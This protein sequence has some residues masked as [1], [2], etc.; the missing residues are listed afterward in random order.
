VRVRAACFTLLDHLVTTYG[1]EFYH[2]VGGLVEVRR[3]S[4]PELLAL[5]ADDDREV[6]LSACQVLTYVLLGMRRTWI[7]Y[8]RY[9]LDLLRP[10]LYGVR[11]LGEL[12]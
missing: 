5:I 11:G 8:H 7:P 9:V 6:A 2:V 1:E 12:L 3:D 4:F 10:H